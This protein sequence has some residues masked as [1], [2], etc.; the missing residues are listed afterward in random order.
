MKEDFAVR[1]NKA[2][3]IRGLKQTELVEKTKLSKS[4]ISQYCSGKVKATQ[5]PLHL[6]AKALSVNEAWLMGHDVE[7]ER[8][9]PAKTSLE[10]D[11]PEVA[12]VL[13]REGKIPTPEKRK[14]IAKIIRAALSEENEE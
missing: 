3:E 4:A 9:A 7:M 2:I 14:Q 13:M 11:W 1:L 5:T 10:S 8:N 6:L 12:N